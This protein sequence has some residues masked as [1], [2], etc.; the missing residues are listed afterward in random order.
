[1]RANED[2]GSRGYKGLELR[3]MWGANY[4]KWDVRENQGRRSERKC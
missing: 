3:K 1:M 2:R 4:G